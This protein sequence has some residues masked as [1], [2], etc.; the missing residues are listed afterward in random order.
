[1]S[2]TTISTAIHEIQD[3]RE[4]S[5]S[6]LPVQRSRRPGAGRKRLIKQDP[7][8]LTTLELLVAPTTRG[9]PMSPLRWTCK[10]TRTLAEQL[11]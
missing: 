10:S 3:L 2:R 11:R 4:S 1:M 6:L 8:L 9:D 7:A 5:G